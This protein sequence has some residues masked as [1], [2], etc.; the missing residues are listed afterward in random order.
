MRPLAG[1]IDTATLTAYACIHS[2]PY[3]HLI[4]NV[5]SPRVWLRGDE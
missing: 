4:R 3:Q 1:A 5:T 2:L